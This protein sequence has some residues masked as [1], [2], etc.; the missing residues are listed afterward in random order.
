M[1]HVRF[2]RLL[3]YVEERLDPG[4]RVRVAR[5][6]GSCPRCREEVESIRTMV[7]ALAPVPDELPGA[8]SDEHAASPCC[9]P[10]DLYRYYRGSLAEERLARVRAH[11]AECGFCAHV[12]ES[13][14]DEQ[15][16]QS[17]PPRPAKIP[18]TRAPRSRGRTFTLGWGLGGAAVAAALVLV[19]FWQAAIPPAYDFTVVAQRRHKV[20][21]GNDFQLEPGAV[22]YSGDKFRIQVE[23]AADLHLYA[24]LF[25]GSGGGQMLFPAP[26]V[27]LDSPLREG[28]SYTIPPGGFWPLDRR[29]GTEI[30]FLVAS[31]RP[32]AGMDKVPEEMVEAAGV[33]GKAPETL[34]AAERFMEGR[35]RGVRS[36]TFQHR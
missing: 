23:P 33:P 18:A 6:L 21:S 30:L 20:R 2:K 10:A 4:E 5:H 9:D 22:L 8:P 11:L 34:K 16:A 25:T 19:F 36:F 17:V 24:F 31:R 15:H 35:F 14:L 29:T 13:Y 12:L 27:Q 26:D 1:F 7:N 28:R 32:L 3:D